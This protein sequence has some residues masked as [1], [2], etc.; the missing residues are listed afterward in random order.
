[1]TV[2]AAAVADALRAAGHAWPAPIHAR[3][4]VGST[5]DLLRTLARDGA[6]ELTVVLAEQQTAGRGRQGRTWVSPPGQLFLSVLL[7][8]VLPPQELTLLP[9]ALGVAVC[10]AARTLGAAAALKWPNDVW[11]GDRKLAG[12]LVESSTLGGAFEAIAGVG[13][14]LCGDAPVETATTIAAETGR[15]PTVAEAAAA[16]LPRLALWYDA[17]VRGSA[18]DVRAA[19]RARSLPWWGREIEVVSGDTVVRGRALGI[20]DTGALQIETAEGTVTLVHA[21][22]A[23]ALRLD[24]ATGGREG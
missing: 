21:G 3:E 19:W 7:R 15:V 1:M 13:L 18:A 10:D 17:L 4:T 14:N 8:P 5:S 16:V 20:D 2:T 6:P 23:R 11:C 12:L 24:A 22:E 9:L